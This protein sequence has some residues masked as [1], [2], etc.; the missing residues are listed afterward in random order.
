MVWAS[1]ES[2]NVA[3][4]TRFVGT[5]VFEDGGDDQRQTKGFVEANQT[6]VLPNHRGHGQ[7]V[8]I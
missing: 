6:Y 2:R 4:T 1:T 5:T 3:V 8:S 7:T